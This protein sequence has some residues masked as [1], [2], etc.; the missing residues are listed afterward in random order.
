M[1]NISSTRFIYYTG[2]PV[3]TLQ[4][5]LVT[6]YSIPLLYDN[7]TIRTETQSEV[8]GGPSA[9][10]L[11]RFR[12]GAACGT[13]VGTA[14]RQSQSLPEYILSYRYCT[15]FRGLANPT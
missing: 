6:K 15:Y 8:W 1:R 4:D 3:Q 2:W 9:L 7:Q 10:A 14:H 11:L 13:A 5:C 12:L